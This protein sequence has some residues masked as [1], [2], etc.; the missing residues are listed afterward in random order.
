MK[1]ILMSLLVFLTVDAAPATTDKGPNTVVKYDRFTTADCSGNPFS[2]FMSAQASMFT[3]D[4]G[5]RSSLFGSL[6][7]KYQP[8]GGE[9]ALSLLDVVKQNQ[10]KPMVLSYSDK[11]CSQL[12]AVSVYDKNIPDNGFPKV[13]Q[14]DG[15]KLTIR[16][17]MNTVKDVKGGCTPSEGVFIK[18]QC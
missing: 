2:T 14:C 1:S 15:S 16:Q 8:W 11:G 3:G 6:M 9:A 7:T 4:A 10:N 5:C 18:I 13:L 12:V 17:T